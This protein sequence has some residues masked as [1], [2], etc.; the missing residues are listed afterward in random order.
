MVPEH[1][2]EGAMPDRDAVSET[3]S[4][5]TAFISDE[6]APGQ[7]AAAAP[8]VRDFE[9]LTLAEA[10]RLLL[11]R[12]F[13][14]LGALIAVARAPAEVLEQAQEPSIFAPRRAAVASSPLTA[15]GAAARPDV[16]ETAQHDDGLNGEEAALSS[17]QHNLPPAD[18]DTAAAVPTGVRAARLVL[19]GA[20]LTAALIGS[21]DMALVEVRTEY[22][23]LEHGLLLLA[24]AFAV[25]LIAEALP[26]L[27]R[28]VR[29][30]GRDEGSMMVAP[31]R[32]DDMAL[33]P[34]TVGRL[35]AVV[36]T[37][38]GA[39]G[40]FLW[41]SGN[42][43]TPQGVAAWFVTILAAVWVLAPEGWS[44]QHLLPNLYRAL[45]QARIELSPS[46]LAL[47]LILVA[48]AYFRFSD[49]PGTPPEMTSDHVEKV[50]DVAGIFDG[51]TNIFFANNGGRESLHFYFA[52]LLSL[53]PGLEI[54]F[55][56]LK[57]ATAVEG[58]IT[59]VVLY[60]AGREIVG[61]GDKQL[62]EV[63][64]L[65]LAAFVAVSAWHV[66][67][68]R[69]GLRIGLTTLFSALVITFLVRG[70]RYNRRWDFLYAGLA[71]GFGLY[72]YQ[73]MRVFPIVIA[74]AGVIGLLVG[75]ASGRVRVTLLG[76]LAGLTVIAAAIFIPLFRYSVEFP[77]D[78]WNR[79][80][81]R[82]LGDAIN[83]ETD[84]NG[85]LVRRTPTLQE[86]IDALITVL[87]NLQMNVRNALLSFHW[88]GD[89]TW[90][91]NSPNQPTLDAFSGALLMV[92][93]AA[94]L[95]RAARRGDPGDW[96]LL[97]ATVLLMLPTVLALAITIE[98]PSHTRM[99]GM[100]PG[101]YLM[102]ALPLGALALDLW[103]LAGR[104]GALLATAGCVALIGLSFNSNAVN[105]FVLYRASYL[106]SALPYS[107]G[108]RELR[109]FAADEGNGYG[110]AFILAYPYWWD[111]RAL[112]IAG[113]APRWSNTILRT[114][115]IAMTLRSGLTRDAADPFA[116][117][118]DRDLLFFGST[119]DEAGSLWLAQHFPAAIETRMTTYMP[120][121][122]D[123][124]R[125]PAPGLD[126]LNA[127][128]VEA[129]LDP[130][131]AR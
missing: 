67:L 27:S 62:G 1:P 76:N 99:S 3:N 15:A 96:F 38:A 30:V 104:L 49:L 98:N 63:V 72:G 117:D 71:F 14:T 22:G 65:L 70:L 114:E 124:V 28:L 34:L 39:F 107:E 91:H 55:T 36:L 86:Q 125:V 56:L 16:H 60:W 8:P 13:A 75:A 115:D 26:F 17:A 100:I 5:E 93:L 37:F 81:T 121:E 74:A 116:L 32:C 92:G 130:V 2:P 40:A 61:K 42:Q 118:P 19:R 52:A 112:G 64:G 119:D 45:R 90:L 47:V 43:F 20:A 57:V 113:G 85:N 23:Y 54:D 105:Y 88:K 33:L 66:F 89:V 77:N 108:G 95:G 131:A 11:R 78:F 127:I 24:L 80:A 48:G 59:L 110:N 50:L 68:S 111:H 69:I 120:R 6:A 51:R 94:W 123:L 84:E 12:P 73:V 106:Q 18:L 97:A 29:R 10:A 9:D 126:A 102:V 31:F 82:L 25:W 46:L 4:P 103:R 58:M 129:G 41:N 122:Y 87:P 128:F 101:I 7:D 21:L 44:P 109:R 53:L 35:F 83:Q 79:S